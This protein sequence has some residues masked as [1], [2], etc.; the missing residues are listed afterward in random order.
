MKKLLLW[1]LLLPAL[2]ACALSL[3]VVAFVF[4]FLPPVVG[5]VAVLVAAV[6]VLWFFLVRRRGGLVPGSESSLMGRQSS[7]EGLL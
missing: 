5:W 1:L 2:L 3:T 7:V 6:V 4:A